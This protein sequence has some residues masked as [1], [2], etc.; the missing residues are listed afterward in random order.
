MTNGLT[1]QCQ[2][3]KWWNIMRKIVLLMVEKGKTLSETCGVPPALQRSDSPLQNYLP[4]SSWNTLL[5]GLG[6]SH[7]ELIVNG[8]QDETQLA[9]DTSV[10]DRS[11]RPSRFFTSVTF[12]TPWMPGDTC[13]RRWLMLASAG[14]DKGGWPLAATAHGTHRGHYPASF[15]PRRAS[16]ESTSSTL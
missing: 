15:T 10:N 13:G 8:S 16:P 14:L 9:A 5:R 4:I 1:F 3:L 12:L 6:L 2:S 11:S 7:R